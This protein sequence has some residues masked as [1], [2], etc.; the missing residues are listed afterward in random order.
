MNN[1]YVWYVSYGSN[2]SKERFLC[3]VL[4]GQP[5]GAK[6]FHTGVRNKILPVGDKRVI[7]DNWERYYG[8]ESAIWGGGVAFIRQNSRKSFTGRAY[9]I[10]KEQFRDVWIQEIG[11]I[12]E[13]NSEKIDFEEVKK[14]GEMD[15][16]DSK[17]GRIIYLGDY[18]KQPLFTFTSKKEQPPN[19]PVAEYMSQINKGLA[20][21]EGL[22]KI[23]IER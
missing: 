9:L 8:S 20:E 10:T 1:D 11:G 17:Y 18:N 23:Q 2:M 5:K 19:Q 3:Y 13:I 7:I 14:A 21:V 22:D 12:P 16:S 15:L 4:G 6:R